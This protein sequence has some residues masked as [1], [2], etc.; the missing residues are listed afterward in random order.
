MIDD[1]GYAIRGRVHADVVPGVCHGL[2]ARKQVSV[3]SYPLKTTK[4]V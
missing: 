4:L 1:K 2:P 3:L